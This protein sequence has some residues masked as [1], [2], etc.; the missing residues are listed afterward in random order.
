MNDINALAEVCEPGTVVIPAGQVNDVRLYRDLLSSGIPD[1]LPK[2]L[3]L[4][5]VRA[6]LTMAQAMLSGPT[7]ADIPDDKPPHSTPL[8]GVRGGLGA[9][10]VATYLARPTNEQTGRQ[11]GPL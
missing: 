11:N 9:S 5:Q 4:D 10:L 1:Y 7:H 2:P 3:S 6:S 8:I